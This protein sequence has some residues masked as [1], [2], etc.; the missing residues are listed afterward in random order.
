MCSYWWSRRVWGLVLSMSWIP[1]WYLRSCKER[2]R[3][4]ELGSARL[5]FSFWGHPRHW[6]GKAMSSYVS[7]P[8]SRRLNIVNTTI[9]NLVASWSKP[10][11]MNGYLTSLCYFILT[12]LNVSLFDSC[13]FR[14]QSATVLFCCASF[15]TLQKWHLRKVSNSTLGPKFPLL[16]LAPGKTKML[17]RQRSLLPSR[18]D[19][20]TSTPQDGRYWTP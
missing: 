17:R 15:S 12:Y 18:Q 19:I 1:L 10:V 4:S 9:P 20:A 6:L 3:S 11:W 2:A 5:W 7:I 8:E 14:Q 16:G 13:I